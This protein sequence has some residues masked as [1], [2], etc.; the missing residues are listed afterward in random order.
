MMMFLLLPPFLLPLPTSTSWSLW[1]VVPPTEHWRPAPPLA[2]VIAADGKMQWCVKTTTAEARPGERERERGG[3]LHYC[4]VLR[5]RTQREAT[6]R[7]LPRTHKQQKKSC[8]CTCAH[9]QYTYR[10]ADSRTRS[11]FTCTSFHGPSPLASTCS[12]VCAPA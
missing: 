1:M 3:N 5:S 11:I 2:P 4:Y 8:Y 6:T 12:T 7:Y 9:T 10:Q